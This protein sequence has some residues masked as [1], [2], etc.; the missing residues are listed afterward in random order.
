MWVSAVWSVGHIPLN[1]QAATTPKPVVVIIM[2][3]C[4]GNWPRFDTGFGIC[5]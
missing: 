1:E 2:A 3:L 5:H 4:F